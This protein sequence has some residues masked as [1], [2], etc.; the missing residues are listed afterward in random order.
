MAATL[1]ALSF[2]AFAWSVVGIIRPRWARLAS[3]RSAAV[4][5]LGSIALLVAGFAMMPTPPADVADSDATARRE[6]AAEHV[7]REPL[8]E[9]ILEVSTRGDL[10]QERVCP[11]AGIYVLQAV[12]EGDNMASAI[13][14]LDDGGGADGL[15]TVVEA[16]MRFA[17]QSRFQSSGPLDLADECYLLSATTG[18]V[19]QRATARLRLAAAHER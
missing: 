18:I 8:P 14:S 3:R 13:L 10:Q 17:N 9:P 16:V 4:V 5:W 15:G 1:I 7:E 11:N 2:L 12:A 19:G 6:V